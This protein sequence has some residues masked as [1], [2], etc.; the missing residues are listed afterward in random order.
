MTDSVILVPLDGSKN[1]LPI[2]RRL[3]KLEKGSV[4]ILRETEETAEAILA[5]A[6]D[7]GAGLIV[8]GA[9][10]AEAAG[11]IGDAALAVLRG[12]YCPVVLVSAAQAPS[13]WT[14][15]RVLAPHDGSPAVSHALGPATELARASGAELIVLQVAGG[16]RALE[17]GSIAPPAYLDQVQHTWP[18]WSREFLHRLASLC[19]LADVPVRLLLAHG[20]PA[21]ETV[22]VAGEE[23][24]D[25]IVLVRTG[26][27]DD[28]GAL[29]AL[30]RAAPCPIM[31]MRALTS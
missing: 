20:A 8:M 2:A 21:D 27:S 30:L 28:A 24:A 19:P 3:A 10:S 16:E 29:K 1:A 25:L 22:R 4:R 13:D 18:V 26:R 6:A 9:H 14:L 7:Q 17:T 31:V 11:E 23:S 12:A 15:R 5:A